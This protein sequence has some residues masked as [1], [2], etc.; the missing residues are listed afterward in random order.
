M[1]DTSPYNSIIFT[2]SEVRDV[3]HLMLKKDKSFNEF[4][5]I[6]RFKKGKED[7][8]KSFDKIDFNKVKYTN[9]ELANKY[10]EQL[11]NLPEWQSPKHVQGWLTGK[12]WNDEDSLTPTDF[13]KKYNID[14][15]FQKFDDDVYYFQEKDNLGL[16][17]YKYDKFG[18]LVKRG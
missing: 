13:A 14:G 15:T 9:I 8:K 5:D 16:M 7:A 1:S 10:N 3:I 6:V 18:K 11:D 4:W 2:S 17:I 12:R